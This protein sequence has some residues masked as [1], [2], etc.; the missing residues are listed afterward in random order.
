MLQEDEFRWI[1][2]LDPLQC[3]SLVYLLLGSL[4]SSEYFD[5]QKTFLPN[6]CL[7]E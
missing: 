3:F 6:K 5:A 7:N 2:S 4:T 1:K